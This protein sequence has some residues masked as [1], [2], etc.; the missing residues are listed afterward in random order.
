[1]TR[2]VAVHSAPGAWWTAATSSFRAWSWC[3]HCLTGHHFCPP[4]RT[5]SI[6]T[7]SRVF[8]S[9][10]PS[11]TRWAGFRERRT[12]MSVCAIPRAQCPSSWMR[13]KREPGHGGISAPPPEWAAHDKQ[14]AAH[15]K[16]WVAR[17]SR[18]AARDSREAARDSREAA[19]DGREAARDSRWLPIPCRGLHLRCRRLHLGCR[20]LPVPCRRLH[21]GCRCLPIP[22]RRLHLG[23]L[24]HPVCCRG[25]PLDR[26]GQPP[27]PELRAPLWLGSAPRARY[28]AVHVQGRV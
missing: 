20:W 13:T 1:M 22:C 23:C 7:P 2:A 25:E 8:L 11:T 12:M 5:S 3:A 10:I 18:E 17:D 27:G 9:S 24:A 21:L 15:D 28:R 19:R 14:W 4:T 6:S 26:Q 16:E